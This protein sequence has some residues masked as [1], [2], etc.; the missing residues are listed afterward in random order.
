MTVPQ[1]RAQ[2]VHPHLHP[3]SVG[4]LRGWVIALAIVVTVGALILGFA[5]AHLL[6]SNKPAP[7]VV[8]S[9]RDCRVSTHT[10]GTKV[11]LAADA[12]ALMEG[13]LRSAATL[14]PS[15]WEVEAIGVVRSLPALSTLDDREFERIVHGAQQNPMKFGETDTTGVIVSIV[16][17]GGE[18]S[19]RLLGLR[20][21]WV[22]GEPAAVQ[23]LPLG[24]DFASNTCTVT[25]AR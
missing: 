10:Q 6:F 20:L 3:H 5:L 13:D 24:I 9:P 7:V 8:T 12:T 17:T 2:W 19:G 22:F 1:D 15:G 23:D 4:V 18:R 16:N 21:T 25:R 14:V 11:Y